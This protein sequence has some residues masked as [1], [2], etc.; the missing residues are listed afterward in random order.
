[1]PLTDI[2]KKAGVQKKVTAG[3]LRDTF[4]VR[5]LNWGE[6]IEIVLRKI[7]LNESTWEDAKEKY[8]RL[9]A[10]EDRKQGFLIIPFRGLSKIHISLTIIL[11]EFT[12][13]LF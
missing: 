5:S 6:G 10:G 11:I 12:I 3:I 8:L 1:M 7:G 2:A 4:V 9:S 13:K